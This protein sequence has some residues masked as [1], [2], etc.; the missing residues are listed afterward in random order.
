MREVLG[1]QFVAAILVTAGLLLWA[2][3]HYRGGIAFVMGLVALLIG[4]RAHDVG[5]LPP[6]PADPEPDLTS[7][8]REQQQAAAARAQAE[9]LRRRERVALGPPHDPVEL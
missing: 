6:P 5:E 7:F 3:L 1:W 8:E 9:F 4:L 2:L